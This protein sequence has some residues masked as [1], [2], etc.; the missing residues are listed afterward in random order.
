M[1]KFSAVAEEAARQRIA[2][3]R[4]TQF[5]AGLRL[6]MPTLPGIV[7]W[8]FVTGLA[9]AK[10]GL[11]PLQSAAMSFFVFSGTAQ[12]AALPLMTVGAPIAL[13]ALTAFLTGLRFL[14]Y[15]ATISRDLARLKPFRRMLL[16]HLT[17]DTGLAVYQ[18]GRKGGVPVQRSAFFLG[19]N[20]PIW[21][22]WQLGT[23]L[24]IAAAALIPDSGD[25]GYL[26]VLAV[27]G[28]TVRMLDSRLNLMAAGVATAVAL[29][30][31]DWAWR[32][33]MLIAILAG[34]TIAVV[35]ERYALRADELGKA[36]K[37]P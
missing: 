4:R 35:A 11:S 3:L 26:G 36:G 19:C 17:T 20:V 13:I 9:L 31:I 8:G 10:T 25:L 23:W 18:L 5:M 12:L 27:L 24:G 28:L 7:S 30:G 32:S 15:S 16:G 1:S 34:V 29:V 33:G 2:R 6:G 37:V 14:V 21:S 22:A